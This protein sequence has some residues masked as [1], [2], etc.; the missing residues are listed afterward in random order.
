MLPWY[1]WPLL[2]ITFIFMIAS[3]VVNWQAASLFLAACISS[4]LNKFYIENAGRTF[5]KEQLD[6]LEKFV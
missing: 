5:T 2:V 4:G 6:Y 1:V 3:F